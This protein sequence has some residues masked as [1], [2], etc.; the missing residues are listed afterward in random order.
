V[1][2]TAFSLL[3]ESVEE[4][5]IV[6]D[7]EPPFK[8]MKSRIT[9]Y[10]SRVLMVC[11]AVIL[12]S[13]G[14]ASTG[15][16]D[17][18]FNINGI[19]T[20]ASD[21]VPAII[22]DAAFDYGTG[23]GTVSLSLNASGSHY[24]GFFVD[25]EIDEASNTFFN[26]F[27]QIFGTPAAGQTWEIDEPGF[28]FGDIYNH[29]TAGSLD[30][31]LGVP[32]SKPDDVSMALAWGINLN[33]GDLALVTFR[34]DESAPASGFYLQHVDPDSDQAIYFS[35]TLT[36]R[37]SGVPEAG[38]TLSLMV[39]GLVTLGYAARRVSYGKALTASS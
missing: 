17:Y 21:P 32:S 31:Q 30:N 3:V 35:S 26:E 18:A 22:N 19:L 14:V 13:V 7:Q 4:M 15:L 39:G 25:H 16:F 20:A 2:E 9:P 24:V 38:S 10:W 12:P 23:L 34:V 36:V 28:V 27:G 37:T 29:I 33:P 5:P 11:G 6:K 1:S 8:I